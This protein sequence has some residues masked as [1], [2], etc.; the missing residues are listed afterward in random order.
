M[1]IMRASNFTKKKVNSEIYK[2]SAFALA[3]QKN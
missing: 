2:S 1:H 3:K